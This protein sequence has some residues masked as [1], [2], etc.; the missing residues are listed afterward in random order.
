MNRF[1]LRMLGAMVALTVLSAIA[2]AQVQDT[3]GT[4]SVNVQP[5]LSIPLVTSPDWGRVTRPPSGAAQYTL[6]YNTGAV[7]NNSGDGY[8]FDD[9]AAGEY[10]VNGAPSGPISFSAAIGAFSDSGLTVIATH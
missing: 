9:G 5:A 1:I 3:S 8:A 2:G 7:T 4:A 10:T 6:N